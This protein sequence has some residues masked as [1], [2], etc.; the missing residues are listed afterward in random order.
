[1][2][3]AFEEI[4]REFYIAAG[5]ICYYIFYVWL[6][7]SVVQYFKRKDARGFELRSI[8]SLLI[9]ILIIYEYGLYD[10]LLTVDA[11]FEEPLIGN[12]SIVN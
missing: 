11:L 2:D 10:Y 8:I 1:V 5:I 9:F 7:V 3:V 12:S 4:F 6:A